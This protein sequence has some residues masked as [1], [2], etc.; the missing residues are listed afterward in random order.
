MAK[1]LQKLELTWIGKGNEPKLEPRILIDDPEK[2]FWYNKEKGASPPWDILKTGE[3][4]QSDKISGSDYSNMLIH[5]DNLL[6]LKAFKQNF[7]G[8]IKCIYLQ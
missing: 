2:S 1:H 7:T 6:A 3:N 8:E 4:Q 5:S